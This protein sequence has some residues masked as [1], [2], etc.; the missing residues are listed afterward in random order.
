MINE[1]ESTIQILKKKLKIPATQLIQDTKL[2][3]LEKEK[4]TLNDELND[5]KEKLLK[6]DDEKKQ[7]EIDMNLLV[8][9]EKTLKKK[10]E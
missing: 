10:K 6:F 7:W 2:I 5:C 4:E 3:E 1:K 9:N 8:E